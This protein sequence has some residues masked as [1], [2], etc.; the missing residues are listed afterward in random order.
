MRMNFEIHV[1]CL[2]VMLVKTKLHVPQTR[3]KLLDYVRKAT[4]EVNDVWH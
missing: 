4:V 1:F 3:S 2:H